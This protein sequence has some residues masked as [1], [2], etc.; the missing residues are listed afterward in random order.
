[1]LNN[2]KR[3]NLETPE[4]KHIVV[5]EDAKLYNPKQPRPMCRKDDPKMRNIDSPITLFKEDEGGRKGKIFYI[6]NQNNRIYVETIDNAKAKRENRNSLVKN[7]ITPQKTQTYI[8]IKTK[9]RT[10]YIA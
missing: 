2:R 6:N 8:I 7:K 10:P 4:D 5:P 3:K 1:M 9:R